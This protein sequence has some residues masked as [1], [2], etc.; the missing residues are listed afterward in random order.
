MKS[1][2]LGL[3]ATVAILFTPVAA[4]AQDSQ[5]SV[6]GNQN[7]AAAVGTG[8]VILQDTNQVSDQTQVGI[9]GYGYGYDAP[10]AQLSIQDNTNEAAAIGHGNTVVQDAD[11]YN[12]QTQVDVGGYLPY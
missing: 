4:F 5:V 7:S 3:L 8:N 2:K 10:D 9:D 6:Q 11:Q 1:S 12:T